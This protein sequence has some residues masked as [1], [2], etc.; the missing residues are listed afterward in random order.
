LVKKFVAYQG[1]CLA[2]FRLH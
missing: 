2:K 1:G